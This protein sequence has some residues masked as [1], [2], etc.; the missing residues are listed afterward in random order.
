M[1]NIR[2]I[3]VWKNRAEG[4]GQTDFGWEVYKI[5]SVT[6]A[7]SI[8]YTFSSS[9]I[10]GNN[11]NSQLNKINNTING[12]NNVYVKKSGDTMT[13]DLTIGSSTATL[14]LRN[15]ASY[16]RA[17]PDSNNTNKSNNLIIRSGGN[18]ILGGGESAQGLYDQNID[19]AQ[20]TGE[21]THLAADG[22]IYLYSN[23][24]TIGN[25]KTWICSTNGSFST[26]GAIS[27][28]GNI[29]A[30]G[31]LTV[32]GNSTLK[33]TLNIGKTTEIT[34][35]TKVSYFLA[36][37]G[38]NSNTVRISKENMVNFIEAAPKN[39][40]VDANT[41]G[42]GT[43]SVYGHV[44][45]INGLTQASHQDGTVLSAYQGKVLNDK[46]TPLN[47]KF[48][49]G[50][51]GNISVKTSTWTPVKTITF[52]SAGTYLVSASANFGNNKTG[53]RVLVIHS[54]T[55][56]GDQNYGEQQ[57]VNTNGNTRITTQRILTV[58][59]GAT[60]KIS[61]WHNG[62]ANV[63]V[64]GTCQIIKLNNQLGNSLNSSTNKI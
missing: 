21:N 19:A 16:L 55:Q 12:L 45:T 26:P 4:E 58:A 33:G 38:N 11:V 54:G 13:G 56:K 44:K 64:S 42:L 10:S 51:S 43:T 53:I 59:A 49:Y 41:Y 57:A 52:T 40:A 32:N 46:I 62:G 7:N 1:A 34:D 37:N 15:S 2:Q 18:L 48:G 29:S 5:G 3:A 8:E 20:G 25:R 63:N 6:D 23:C 24:N 36:N 60:A 50:N 61:V 39:H 28:S 14:T 17:Y 35:K 27:A 47:S 22:H 31:T 30:T 9:D